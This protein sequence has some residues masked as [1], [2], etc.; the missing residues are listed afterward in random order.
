MTK[1]LQHIAIIPDGNRRWAKQKGKPLFEG[2]RYA[3]DH[4]IPQ[5]YDTVMELGV[6]YCTIWALSPEN[7]SKRSKV[8]IQNLLQLLHLF[9]YKHI[10]EMNEKGIRVNIIGNTEVFPEK[11]QKDL[12]FALSKTRNNTK[13]TLTFALN[14]GG[15]DE[16]IRAIHK[17][18]SSIRKLTGK[19]QHIGKD[20]FESFLDTADIPDPDLIIRTGGEK[21][22]SGFMLWQ[23]EYAE[24]A[25]LDMMFPDFSPK[26]LRTCVAGFYNRQRRFGK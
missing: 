7:Y 16:I 1:K 26:D 14:Y 8:E 24:Y 25:F 20:E 23:A 10:D 5:L 6:S 22:T 11:I 9:L 3:A 2:H 13:L 4:T 18:Q 21:R 12:A 17:V 15:R 19:A